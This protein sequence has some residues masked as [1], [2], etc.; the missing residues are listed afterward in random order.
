MTDRTL[1]TMTADEIPDDANA[2]QDGL[3]VGDDG[4]IGRLDPSETEVDG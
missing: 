3:I 2:L 1:E 4:I